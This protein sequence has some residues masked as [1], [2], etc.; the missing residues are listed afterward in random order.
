MTT[1]SIEYSPDYKSDYDSAM[2][3]G[4]K[5]AETVVAANKLSTERARLESKIVEAARYWRRAQGE[6]LH[7]AEVDATR[8]LV[9]RAWFML[10]KTV[11]ALNEF[12]SQ[13]K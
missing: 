13:Q 5:I 3:E 4:R 6:S 7:I 11:D 9:V 2:D 12:E 10:R 8:L 1:G